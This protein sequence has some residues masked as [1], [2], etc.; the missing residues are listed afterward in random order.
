MSQAHRKVI[1][2]LAWFIRWRCQS[3]DNWIAHCNSS[4]VSNPFSFATDQR[5][6]PGP[7]L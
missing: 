3:C 5:D 4:T 7:E 6:V 2:T 1:F